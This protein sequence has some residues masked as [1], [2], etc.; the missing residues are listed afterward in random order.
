VTWVRTVVVGRGIVDGRGGRVLG[1]RG[2]VDG[3]VHGSVEPGWRSV[4]GVVGGTVVG[5]SVVP[6][7]VTATVVLVAVVRGP[8]EV[9]GIVGLV[10]E[11]G[12]K[13]KPVLPAI[14][15]VPP[16]DGGGAPGRVVPVPG[17]ITLVVGRVPTELLAVL[18]V[19]AARV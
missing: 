11:V 13:P 12:A 10:G 8:A 9:S 19:P 16:S 15:W 3:M 4:V 1:G 2:T 17:V 5:V 14:I 7:T 6:G 18:A